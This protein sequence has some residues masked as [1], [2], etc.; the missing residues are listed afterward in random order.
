MT[1]KAV[2]LELDSSYVTLFSEEGEFIR[3][4]ARRLPQAR[5]IGQSVSLNQIKPSCKLGWA[6]LLAACIFLLF[7]AIPMFIPSP[8]MAWVSLDNSSSLELL[9][10]NRF[11]IKE[12]RPLN[13]GASN[14][15]E[16]CKEESLTFPALVEEFINWSVQNGDRSLLI[17]A[18]GDIQIVKTCL[19][20]YDNHDIQVVALE[21]NPQVRDEAEKMGLSAG[22]ALFMAEASCRGD[23]SPEKI[24]EGNPIDTLDS[25]G[26]NLEAF[27]ESLDPES[28]AEKIK[29]LPPPAP[30]DPEDGLEGN[31]P[32]GE[33]SE[34]GEGESI[35]PSDEDQ[36][37]EHQGRI[38]PRGL[39]KKDK[40]HPGVLSISRSGSW[41]KKNNVPK[42]QQD[43]AGQDENEPPQ[44]NESEQPVP[45]SSQ[46][47]KNSKDKDNPGKGNEKPGNQDK[48]EKTENP[49]KGSGKPGNQDENEETVNL[50][51]DKPDNPGQNKEK[52]GGNEGQGQEKSKGNSDPAQKDNKGEQ[53]GQ[54]HDNQD[55]KNNG[56]NGKP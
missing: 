40:N 1:K 27:V 3:L 25:A 50:G 16:D 17:T 52:T 24:K 10:D 12:I 55:K 29:D 35:E 7:V 32:E 45:D 56:K 39:A 41:G 53:K 44:Q 14:F 47:H 9:V 8:A 49:G 26:I 13:T 19:S 22:R 38:L 37:E 2:I 11:K 5:Y 4:P 21:V 34:S 6:P 36:G 31:L 33:P 51:K 54:G 28:Q 43:K 15:L 30:E 42:G 20:E 23:I 46:D 48:D 18:T